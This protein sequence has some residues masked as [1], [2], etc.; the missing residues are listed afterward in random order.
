MIYK[1]YTPSIIVQ[2]YIEKYH[3]LHFNLKGLPYSPTRSYYPRAEQ[4]LTFDPRGRITGI[5]KQ[6]GEKQIR[7]FSYLSQ[8][9]TST[10]DLRFE[11]D[12]LMLKVVFKPGAL[13][14]LLGI[15]LQE[16]NEKYIDAESVIPLEV[17]LVNEQ[18]ANT[19]DYG[20]MIQIV[21]KYLIGKIQKV[22]VA[23]Q[24]IDKVF[25]L[26]NSD[27]NLFSL[28]W[29]ASQACLST[30]QLERKYLERIGV[31]PIVYHR[32]SRF[33]KA[34]KMK[35]DNPFLSWFSIA[36][37]HGYTDLQHLI[38]DFKQFSG[39]TPTNLINEEAGSIHRQLKL[40]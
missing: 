31:S 26:I 22:K 3:L 11:E 12:Y 39:S 5:N 2:E 24:P 23:R 10:Y 16:F 27:T 28:D 14:R 18:L 38:K 29:I 9:Q 13:F 33:N 17:Q 32:I 21:E 8:Q 30:R 7:S 25:D 36:I 6:T 15:P 4:C 37:T 35:E 40:V 19:L 1:I 34:L 20:Q